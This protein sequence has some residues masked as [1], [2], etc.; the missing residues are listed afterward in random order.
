MIRPFE[1]EREETKRQAISGRER[2]LLKEH[3]R[4]RLFHGVLALEKNIDHVFS[5]FPTAVFYI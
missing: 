1:K 3:D 2:M 5:F 4:L